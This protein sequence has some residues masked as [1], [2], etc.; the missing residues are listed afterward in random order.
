MREIGRP[1]GSRVELAV[2][3]VVAAALVIAGVLLLA[4]LMS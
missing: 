2:H 1:G 3:L 4:A